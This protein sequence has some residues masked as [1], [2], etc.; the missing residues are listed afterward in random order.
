MHTFR[1]YD[2]ANP[3]ERQRALEDISDWIGSDRMAI[4]LQYV[5]VDHGHMNLQQFRVLME[6]L[7]V[8][9][10]PVDVLADELG[11]QP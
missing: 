6:F 10:Y 4:L 1:Q 5:Q 3:A 2:D 11:V 7:G 8:T 9:G